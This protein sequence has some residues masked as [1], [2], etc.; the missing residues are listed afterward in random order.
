[1]VYLLI[2]TTDTLH[3]GLFKVLQVDTVKRC[4]VMRRLVRFEKRILTLILLIHNILSLY[5]PAK[6]QYFLDK[7]VFFSV[8][9]T[10]FADYLSRRS[11]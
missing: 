5:Q 4:R 2:L 3:E 7:D 9:L 11:I 10:L 1:M 8:L 6:I